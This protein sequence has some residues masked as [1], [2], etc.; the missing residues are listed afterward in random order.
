MISDLLGIKGSA[1]F[2]AT[3]AAEFNPET[4]KS[5]KISGD[6]D[7]SAKFI[8]SITALLG[9]KYSRDVKPKNYF[10]LQMVK[11]LLELALDNILILTQPAG[12]L[13]VANGTTSP[14]CVE[15][16]LLI[17]APFQE[18]PSKSRL[19]WSRSKLSKSQLHSIAREPFQCLR[20]EYS[21]VRTF[22]PS[23]Q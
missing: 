8:V 2:S 13:A 19:R 22:E 18:L 4:I 3:G 17:P 9:D 11:I 23:E 5:I 15:R 7:A 6:A 1:K 10:Q 21:V 20:P 14:L 12:N 16:Q